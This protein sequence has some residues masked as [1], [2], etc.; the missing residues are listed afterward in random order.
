MTD[1]EMFIK[2]AKGISFPDTMELLFTEKILGTIFMWTEKFTICIENF[3]I[4]ETFFYV[5]KVIQN[6][7]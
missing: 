1:M 7:Y 3:N 5:T 2:K 4:C 6:I